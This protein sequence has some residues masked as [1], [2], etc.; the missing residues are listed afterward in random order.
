MNKIK[1]KKPEDSQGSSHTGQNILRPAKGQDRVW[2]W[3]GSEM[4]RLAKFESCLPINAQ[5]RYMGVLD[6]VWIVLSPN[7]VIEDLNLAQSEITENDGFC[8]PY[9]HY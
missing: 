2:T 9:F 1:A 6:Q 8:V 7:P 4:T 3:S 5:C